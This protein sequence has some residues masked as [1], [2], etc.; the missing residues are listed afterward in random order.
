VT[1]RPPEGGGYR[2]EKNIE[3]PDEM[4]AKKNGA[5]KNTERH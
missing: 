4:E 2:G 1:K 5:P 3:R